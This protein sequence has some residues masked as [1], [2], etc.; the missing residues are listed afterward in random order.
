MVFN[1]P[2]FA[3]V[4]ALLPSFEKEVKTQETQPFPKNPFYFS[5]VSSTVSR[6]GSLGSAAGRGLGELSTPT[7]SSQC[8]LYPLKSL[9]LRFNNPRHLEPTLRAGARAHPCAA[10][11]RDTQRIEGQ[12]AVSL[13]QRFLLSRCSGQS[14][15]SH[16][17]EKGMKSS[18]LNLQSWVLKAQNH[19]CRTGH[20]LISPRG[21]RLPSRPLP[22]EAC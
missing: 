15:R 3:L 20:P 22:D 10:R 21:R 16:P 17:G 18:I 14:L 8:H 4:S 19:C 1:V 9:T 2:G 12:R 5:V 7:P 11:S 6:S 13:L